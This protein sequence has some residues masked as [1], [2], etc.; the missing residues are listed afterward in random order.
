MNF[1][2]TSRVILFG[3]VLLALLCLAQAA[4][5]PGYYTWNDANGNQYCSEHD[6]TGAM[7]GSGALVFLLFLVPCALFCVWADPSTRM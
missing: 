4:C 3:L 1:T 7:W 2:S 5:P 6:H